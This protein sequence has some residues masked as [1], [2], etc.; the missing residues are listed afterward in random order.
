[1]SGFVQGMKIGGF[2][3]KFVKVDEQW[4][5]N[6]IKSSAS[7][8]SSVFNTCN[9]GLLDT[10]GC[11][12]THPEIDGVQYTYLAL[13]DEAN[14]SSY[15]RLSDM[16][17]GSTGRDGL[18]WMTILSCNMLFSNNI[19]SM[20][21]NSKLPNNENLHLLLGFNSFSYGSPFLGVNYASNLV[22]QATIWNSFASSCAITYAEAAKNP[23]ARNSMTNGVI[24]R[25]MGQENCISDTL[26]FYHDPDF[27]TAFQILDQR[28]FTP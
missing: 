27:N 23:A 15:V 7:G 8:G 10:H 12:G 20:A 1:V 18:R 22:M 9:F 4:G 6:D 13:F 19:T 2:K 14:G 28:V 21:N 26:Y 17:F 11:Y 16:D 5:P 3:Q 25:V 24:A